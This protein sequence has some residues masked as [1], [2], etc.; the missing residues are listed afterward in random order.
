MCWSSNNLTLS[1]NKITNTSLKHRW[2]SHKSSPAGIQKQLSGISLPCWR[3][4]SCPKLG[5]L[6]LRQIMGRLMSRSGF[7]YRINKLFSELFLQNTSI[8]VDTCPSLKILLTFAA[9]FLLQMY[10]VQQMDLQRQLV[11]F[12]SHVTV[13]FGFLLKPSLNK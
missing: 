13:G 5:W 6:C 2:K 8:I 7:L 9:S 1:D 11:T 4:R 10:V 12:R 3:T